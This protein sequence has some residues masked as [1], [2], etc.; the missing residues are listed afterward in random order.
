ML[1]ICI[2]KFPNFI[3]FFK[4]SLLLPRTP[5]FLHFSDRFFKPPNFKFHQTVHKPC[6]SKGV[7]VLS[8]CSKFTRQSCTL[9]LQKKSNKLN[10][11]YIRFDLQKIIYLSYLQNWKIAG[12]HLQ[13]K[14]TLNKHY[15]SGFLLRR[16]SEVGSW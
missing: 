10:T 8:H 4:K 15:M 6:M 9:F 1:F 12:K 14:L 7:L 13:K 16:L 3:S 11:S 2:P 5:T